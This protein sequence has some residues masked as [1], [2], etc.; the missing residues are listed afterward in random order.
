MK[1]NRSMWVETRERSIRRF[2][3]LLGLSVFALSCE[4][5]VATTTDSVSSMPVSTS[6]TS[7]P[8]TTSTVSDWPGVEL[9]VTNTEGVFY[10]DSGGAVTRLVKGRMAYAVDDTR[11]GLL[12]QVERGRS[13]E[14]SPDTRVW[15]VPQ[16]S[17]EAQELLVPTPGAGHDLTLYDAFE[18]DS[19]DVR[20]LYVRSETPQ[21]WVHEEL[22]DRVRLLDIGDRTV[23]ELASV[24]V[25]E[26][27][28]SGLSFGGGLVAGILIGEVS[29]HCYLFDP[30]IVQDPID[31]EWEW[32]DMVQVPGLPELVC[33][34]DACPTAC[35]ISPN[36]RMLGYLNRSVVTIADT[37]SGEHVTE[38]EIPGTTGVDLSD[39]LLL[40]NRTDS[41]AIVIDLDNPNRTFDVPVAGI[42]RF[43]TG[44]VEIDAPVIPPS[45]AAIQL[46]GDG[47]GVVD[48]GDP[49]EQVMAVL[50][51]ALGS[52]S[53]D[54]T[55]TPIPQDV[56]PAGAECLNQ[57]G[58]YPCHF[59]FRAVDW[60]DFQVRFSDVDGQSEPH[61]AGWSQTGGTVMQT[62]EGIGIGSSIDDLRRAYGTNLRLPVGA[63]ECTGEWYLVISSSGFVTLV[64]DKHPSDPSAQVVIVRAGLSSDC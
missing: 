58:G 55:I 48:F 5:Q 18:D 35:V 54:W 62:P 26:G 20:V 1:M 42:A 32:P 36:G 14:R 15:W 29:S 40:V 43:V 46:R 57:S 4:E 28:T 34:G 64:F 49:V 60:A 52:P 53:S 41:P 25:F 63:D 6:S 44:P 7:L 16:G 23:A 21:G 50:V 12:F 22:I 59:Y 31:G 17:G 39:Q 24:G 37:G 27:G 47:L 3:L 13:F 19:G 8:E 11:G 38:L 45:A 61:F 33:E 10:V 9:L 2:A 56:V 30:N 51:T